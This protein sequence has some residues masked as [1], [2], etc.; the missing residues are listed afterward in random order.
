MDFWS[1]VRLLARRWYVVIAGLVVTGVIVALVFRA[2]PPT[3]S[4][5]SQQMFITTPPTAQVVTGKGSVAGDNPLLELGGGYN[6]LAE[7]MAKIM[8][9]VQGQLAVQEAGGAGDYVVDTVPGDAPVVSISVEATTPQR[10]L[11]TEKIVREVM[12]QTLESQQRAAGADARTFVVVRSVFEPVDA[13]YEPASRVRAGGALLVIGLAMTVGLAF[14]V[15]S[16]AQRRRQGLDRPPSHPG[17]FAD[18]PKDQDELVPRH[19]ARAG[20]RS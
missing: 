19:Q 8:N 10:A 14:L 17:G 3:Y 5:T 2:I 15:E 13:V 7:L 16:F 1:S 11:R 18:E 6:V 4:A 9:G 12:A 20:F